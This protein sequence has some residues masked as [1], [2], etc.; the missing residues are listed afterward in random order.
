MVDG[1]KRNLLTVASQFLQ[2]KRY[3]PMDLM[4]HNRSVSGVNLGHMWDELELLGGHLDLLLG[5]AQRG[6]LQPH[7]DSVWPLSKAGEAHAHMQARK[8]V[9]KMLFDCEAD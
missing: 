8:S 5:M 4:N 1:Q 9:G 2:L 6:L 7:I 3:S